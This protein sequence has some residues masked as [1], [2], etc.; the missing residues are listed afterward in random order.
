MIYPIE[1]DEEPSELESSSVPST[2]PFSFFFLL[3]LT[4]AA[5]P[6]ALL[7]PFGEALSPRALL[8]EAI[9]FKLLFNPL[10]ENL[11]G[12]FGVAASPEPL[13]ELFKLTYC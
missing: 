5:A 12:F 1:L 11:G 4:A 6:G 7:V 10:I 8:L 2:F 13:A 9:F 3:Y